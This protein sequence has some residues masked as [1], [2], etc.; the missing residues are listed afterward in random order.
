ML[1]LGIILIKRELQKKSRNSILI[2]KQSYHQQLCIV[3][4]IISGLVLKIPRYS[5]SM[6][7]KPSQNNRKLTRHDSSSFV[8]LSLVPPI[9]SRF[10]HLISLLLEIETNRKIKGELN[11]D[12][13]YA[14]L[15]LLFW[16]FKEQI[17]LFHSNNEMGIGYSWVYCDHSISS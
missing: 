16:S 6:E 9:I 14:S 3:T 8:H 2:F 12:S 1:D 11:Y 13:L 5:K 10:P 4:I 7:T 15:Q 17:L